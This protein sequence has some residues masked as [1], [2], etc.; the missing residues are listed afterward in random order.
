[1]NTGELLM[2]TRSQLDDTVGVDSTLHWPSGDLIRYA[3]AARDRLFLS[4]RKLII[5]SNTALD[6]SDLPLCSIP[7]I[8]GTATYSLSKKILGIIRVK[9]AS[10]YQLLPPISADDLYA[11]YDWQ[12]LPQGDP[13]A[14]CPDLNSDSITLVPTPVANDTA[15]L[16]VYRF[17]L[18]KLSLDD[19][20]AD[21]GFREEYHEDLIPWM[22]NLAFRKQDA[23]VY[24]PGLADEY[25][26]IF[27]D[28]AAEI[29]LEMHR[30][31][32]VPKLNRIPSAFRAR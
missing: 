6:D 30:H 5:D 28:R 3:N 20:N 10:Q 25:S 8:D 14:Y 26:K 18:V 11:G 15:T 7:I 32:N 29:K 24:N 12:N 27:T 13:W 31:S 19:L 4:V 23:E 22:L 2:A 9:L 16:T 17:P 21:L 1:M